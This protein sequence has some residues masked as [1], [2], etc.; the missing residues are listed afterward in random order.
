MFGHIRKIVSDNKTVAPGE[1][2]VNVKSVFRKIVN[3][4]KTVTSEMETVNG[5][6]I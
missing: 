3:N 6:T 1:E 5:L 4:N 2:T